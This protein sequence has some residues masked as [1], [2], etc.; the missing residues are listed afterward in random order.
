L[1]N[2]MGVDPVPQVE[3]ATWL[4]NYRA[5]VQAGDFHSEVAN[6]EWHR[7]VAHF[8]PEHP[9]LTEVEMLKR[10]YDFKRANN[11]QGGTV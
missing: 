6:Q 7:L 4:H 8:G 11:I 1:A 5:L 2:I 9:V 10:L 3:E